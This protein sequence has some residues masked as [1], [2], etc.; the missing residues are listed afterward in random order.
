[1]KKKLSIITLCIALVAVTAGCGSHTHAATEWKSDLQK[2]WQVCEECGEEFNAGEHSCD[3]FGYCEECD[4]SIT[5]YGDG[6]YGV[7]SYDEQGTMSSQID[8]DAE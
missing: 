8:Y 4:S 2:H 6:T 5:D 1:M 7:I 3:E